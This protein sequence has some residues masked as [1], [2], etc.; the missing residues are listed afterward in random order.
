MFITCDLT[1][2]LTTLSLLHLFHLQRPSSVLMEED[3]VDKKG[4]KELSNL[5]L[6]WCIDARLQF[7]KDRDLCFDRDFPKRLWAVRFDY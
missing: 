6:G 3:T 7:E 5:S 1:C 2:K 4:L